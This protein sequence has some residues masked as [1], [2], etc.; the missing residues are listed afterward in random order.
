[1]CGVCN[2]RRSLTGCIILYCIIITVEPDTVAV[3][4]VVVASDGTCLTY[5]T[6]KMKC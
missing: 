6:P 3:V 5:T 4:V 2:R 1:M